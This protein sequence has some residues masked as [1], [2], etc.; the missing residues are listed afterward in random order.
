[1]NN[2]SKIITGILILILITGV[3]AIYSYAQNNPTPAPQPMSLSLRSEIFWSHQKEIYEALSLT[4]TQIQAVD[5]I[6]NQERDSCKPVLDDLKAR[7]SAGTITLEEYQSLMRTR[8]SG[9]RE[10]TLQKIEKIFTPEQAD[11]YPV[12]LEALNQ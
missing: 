9:Y 3:P 7:L 10:L 2:T 5:E 11:M 6:I 1:M 4:E 8:L 12:V